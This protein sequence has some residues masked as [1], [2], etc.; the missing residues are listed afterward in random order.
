MV[1]SSR[2]RYYDFRELD[3][4]RHAP[5][6]LP[7]P[8]AATV[9][10]PRLRRHY[11]RFFLFA[12]AW[13]CVL[14][15]GALL[16]ATLDADSFRF[17]GIREPGTLLPYYALLP[18]VTLFGIGYA[19]VGLDLARNHAILVLGALGKTS[20]FLAVMYS[21]TRGDVNLVLFYLLTGDMIQVGLFVEFLWRMH[22]S[23]R[24]TGVE[25]PRVS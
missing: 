25:P 22:V 7:V 3:L 13:N 16:F 12:G 14:T 20:F 15:L 2:S 19:M 24:P 11:R 1:D 21:Y 8:A 9:L 6:A 4:P 18:Q 10:S 5:A 23:L 17:V